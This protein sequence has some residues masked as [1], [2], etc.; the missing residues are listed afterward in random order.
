MVDDICSRRQRSFPLLPANGSL[1]NAIVIGAGIAGL[2]TTRQ[3]LRIGVQVLV[4][5][6]NSSVG[7]IWAR[8][9]DGYGLQI[10]WAHYQ[11]P[12]F[13]WPKELQP[14]AEYASGQ[15]VHAYINAYVERFGLMPHIRLNCKLLRLRWCAEQLQWEALFCDTAKQKF[16]KAKADYAVICSGLYSNPYIPHYKGAE[17]FAGLQLH[18]KDFTS[19]AMARGRRVVIVG[20]G[21][22]ALDCMGGLLASRVAASVTLLYRRAHWPVPR[23]AVGMPVQQLLF[24]R[25]AAAMLP[26]Y[27]AAGRVDRAVHA[28]TSSLKRLFWR[29]MECAIARK[30]K[31]GS[32]K[33]AV[34]G[35]GLP[36]DLFYGGQILEDSSGELLQCETLTTIKGEINQFVARGVILQDGSFQ[37]ADVILYC[38]GYVKTYDYLEG[39]MREQLG[40]QKDGLYLY[41]NCLP[42]AVP[43]LAYIGSEVSTHSNIVTDSLQ[44]MW[45]AHVLTGAVQLPPPDAMAADVREQQRWRREV[46]PA[47]RNRGA[48]LMMYGMQYHDQLLRDMG[49]TPRRKGLNLLAECFGA[50]SPEDYQ[51][52]VERIQLPAVRVAPAEPSQPLDRDDGRSGSPEPERDLN[53]S[54]SAATPRPRSGDAAPST[55]VASGRSLAPAAAA[56]VSAAATAAASAVSA[57]FSRAFET[58]GLLLMPRLQPQLQLP[59][60]AVAGAGPRTGADASASAPAGAAS[61][62]AAAPRTLAHLLR[63]TPPS[64]RVPSAQSPPDTDPSAKHE[65]RPVVAPAAAAVIK[66]WP[67]M[68][69]PAAGAAAAAAV[70]GGSSSCCSLHPCGLTSAAI[71]AATTAATVTTPA[72]T[73]CRCCSSSPCAHAQAASWVESS[74]AGGCDSSSRTL[75]GHRADAAGGPGTPNAGRGA[76][77]AAASAGCSGAGGAGAGSLNSSGNSYG[78][79][80]ISPRLQLQNIS[81]QQR[82]RPQQHVQEMRSQQ[83]QQRQLSQVS[84]VTSLMTALSGGC[85]R[86]DG[87]L[88]TLYGSRLDVCIP[89]SKSSGSSG[90]SGSSCRVS[91]RVVCRLP[92]STLTSSLVSGLASA[93]AAASG[94]ALCRVSDSVALSTAADSGG[95][96]SGFAP[97]AVA[98]AAA[99]TLGCGSA[100]QLLGGSACGSAFRRASDERQRQQPVQEQQ[101]VQQQQ[102]VQQQQHDLLQWRGSPAAADSGEVTEGETR[103][104]AATAAALALEA[105]AEALEADVGFAAISRTDADLSG[106]AK[107]RSD[108]VAPST[109]PAVAAAAAVTPANP[110]APLDS[111]PLQLA[112]VPGASCGGG[113]SAARDR[114]TRGRC[115]S[116]A[117]VG[118]PT[119]D[120]D[121]SA[122]V[123]VEPSPRASLSAWC[124]HP[125]P[126]APVSEVCSSGERGKVSDLTAMLAQDFA[127]GGTATRGSG[128]VPFTADDGGSGD[129]GGGGSSSPCLRMGTSPTIGGARGDPAPAWPAVH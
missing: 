39:E 4:L 43:H 37:P 27:Y 114:G 14:K 30:F 3:L 29:G 65:G 38:T 120:T 11:F 20:A 97:V 6:A 50:Y 64:W 107:G 99:S 86:A 83:A 34:P 13:L 96:P 123:G 40:L 102:L 7:G 98:A 19:M 2:C 116:G 129:G 66:S 21:K 112:S 118:A 46:M 28:V 79:A 53:R 122:D 55:G 100:R 108:G 115:R 124:L 51:P 15:E 33:L 84:G 52:L 16:F 104:A 101:Q 87:G 121:A 61:D 58:H 119:A 91:S 69:P 41:R 45:L 78:P 70:A 71:T 59:A 49:Q 105:E 68:A 10:P 18:A 42:C 56:A 36:G 63:T 35:V 74:F 24:G 75:L 103:P 94:S 90:S 88:H 57:D 1:R 125:R 32:G 23:S 31:L 17:T 113:V 85:R 26:P 89:D 73:T 72:A 9:Y 92:A 80:Q 67:R 5:E 82:R 128:V 111:P 126:Q 25:A 117:G 62:E 22:T 109:G 106:D 44:A 76:G 48:V 93:S 60:G 12:E 47:Q 77:P 110:S 8:N 127:I 81:Q 95:V 54:Q